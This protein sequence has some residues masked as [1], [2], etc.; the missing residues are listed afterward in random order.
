[1]ASERGRYDK[2]AE[3][4][5]GGM[6]TV[7]L[8]RAHGLGGFERL[9]A[10]KEMH[11]HLAKEPEFVAMFL[12]EA[13]LAAQIRHPNVVATLDVTEN[14][15]GSLSLVME[16][17]EGP[18]LQQILRRAVRQHDRVPIDLGLRLFLDA[19]SGLEAAHEL[20]DES[21]TP[22]HIVHRDVS[23][24][25]I[26]VSTDGIAKLT[27]F[28]VARA[29]SRLSSTRTGTVKGKVPYMAPEQIRSKSLDRRTDVYAAGAVLWE[30]LACR[31]LVQGDSEV[32]MMYQITEGVAVSPREV[33]PEV[34]EGV[35]R[36]C[37]KALEKNPDQRYPSA[38]EFAEALEA[39]ARA[40]GVVVA[41]HRAVAAYVRAINVH[42]APSALAPEGR[43]SVIS[44]LS[45]VTG[46]GSGP[47]SKEAPLSPPATPARTALTSTRDAD[48][49]ASKKRSFRGVFISVGAVA[50]AALAL[51][52]W[53]RYGKPPTD[54]NG[55]NERPAAQGAPVETQAPPATTAAVP[56]PAASA[57]ASA[58]TS[59]NAAPAEVVQPAVAKPAAPPSTATTSRTA[60]PPV[61]GGY[62]PREL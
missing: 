43:R 9:V 32:A 28:G 2:L 53:I 45:S 24:Q 37:L 25:N 26:L 57:T 52:V 35:A 62:R 27:D 10:V 5:S 60:K 47:A 49:E 18:S 19:L 34:P 40:E 36:A 46:S 59:A 22:L 15:E 54:A 12:D 17:V 11:P 39:S 1:M 58:A 56:P 44:G 8:A 6:A 14:E 38:A 55:P 42:R 48:V 13:R 29:D 61:K 4:A 30:M 31:R 7:Y 23:P 3:I 51:F 21:G 20:T 16:Y 33:I 50:V 41:N